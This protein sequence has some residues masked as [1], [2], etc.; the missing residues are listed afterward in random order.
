MITSFPPEIERKAD[1][2]M[3]KYM[4]DLYVVSFSLMIRASRCYDVVSR[5]WQSK[6]VLHSKDVIYSWAVGDDEVI[7]FIPVVKLVKVARF[8]AEDESVLQANMLIEKKGTSS[9]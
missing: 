8:V 7:D 3:Q 2:V 9:E 5:T 1:S 6:R 4:I